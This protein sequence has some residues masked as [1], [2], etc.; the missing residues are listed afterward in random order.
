MTERGEWEEWLIYFLRGIAVQSEEAVDR[1]QR[2]DALLSHWKRGLVS[3]QSRLPER[4][5]DLFTEN[6]FGTVGGVAGRLG[7]AFTTAQRAIDRLGAAGVVARVGESRR[8][9]VYCAEAILD[10]LE[11]PPRLGRLRFLGCR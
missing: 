9:R 5:L 10:V 11:E 4:A 1:I 3:G 2:I 7:V 6:P 8:N